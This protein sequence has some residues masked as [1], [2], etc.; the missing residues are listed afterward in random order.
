MM[1][2]ILVVEDNELVRMLLVDILSDAGYAVI[3]AANYTDACTLLKNNK[4]IAGV[5]SDWEFPLDP[6]KNKQVDAN[7]GSKVIEFVQE[8]NPEMPIFVVTG[9]SPQEVGK[10]CAAMKRADKIQV[11][12]KPVPFDFI[13]RIRK[14]IPV[15]SATREMAKLPFGTDG[16]VY[17][18]PQ[19]A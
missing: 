19:I 6:G 11:F 16:K 13:A 18:Q 15:E 3:E 8:R 12:S 14:A 5:V 10:I 7:A 1:P 4:A 17:P 9:S 2:T